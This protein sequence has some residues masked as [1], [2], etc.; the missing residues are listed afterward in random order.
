MLMLPV[1]TTALPRLA[2]RMTMG[3]SAVAVLVM[4]GMP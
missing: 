4:P 3:A 2:A 1:L